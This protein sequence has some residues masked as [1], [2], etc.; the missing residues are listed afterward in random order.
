MKLDLP[1]L[2]FFKLFIAWTLFVMAFM[3]GTIYVAAH[4]LNKFW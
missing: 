4:F 2:P 1:Q 3:G